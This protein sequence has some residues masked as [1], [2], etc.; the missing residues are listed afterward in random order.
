MA[1][2]ES[3]A[4]LERLH[5]HYQVANR[6]KFG[7]IL[8][9]DYTIVINP[10]LRRLTGRIGYRPRVIEISGFHLRAYGYEDARATLEHEMLHL[11]LHTLGHPSGHTPRFKRLARGLGIRVFHANPYPQNRPSRH[12]YVYECP[13]CSRMVFRQRA[14]QRAPL[15]CGVCCR[16]FSDG[17]WD[18]RFA[19][20]L[21]HK[22][23]LA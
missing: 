18:A 10:L 23:K 12:R 22:I 13:A 14:H 8:P 6:D 17:R 20:E 1:A 7:G 9:A 2:N 16:A 15:A 5:A 21:R 3:E 4:V 19:L 11:Y